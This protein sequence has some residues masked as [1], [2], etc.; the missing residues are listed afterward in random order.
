MGEVKTA[1]SPLKP[2]T[3]KSTHDRRQVVNGRKVDTQNRDSLARPAA[4]VMKGGKCDRK[5]LAVA[6]SG[7]WEASL[8][9]DLS[10]ASPIAT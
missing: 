1:T 5:V 3:G 7:Y 10:N 9:T 6:K 4:N 8:R 2:R